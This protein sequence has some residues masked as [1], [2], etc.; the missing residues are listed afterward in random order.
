MATKEDWICAC[1]YPNE[2][3]IK[4]C[5]GCGK[6]PDNSKEGNIFLFYFCRE[7]VLKDGQKDMFEN[8]QS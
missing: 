8:R 2:Y 3:D 7:V 4:E 6:S 1:G 5:E